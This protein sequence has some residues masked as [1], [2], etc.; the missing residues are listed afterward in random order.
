MHLELNL[1]MLMTKMG[2]TPTNSQTQCDQ[3]KVG[4]ANQ[5][6][7]EDSTMEGATRDLDED[8]EMTAAKF[9]GVLEKCSRERNKRDQGQPPPRKDVKKVITPQNQTGSNDE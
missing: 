1:K 6:E 2:V 8:F 9:N 3:T 7:R 5:T 4:E